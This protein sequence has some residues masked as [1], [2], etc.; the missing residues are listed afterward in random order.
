MIEKLNRTIH[1]GD[2]AIV[3]ELL[4]IETHFSNRK[5]YTYLIELLGMNFSK[6]YPHIKI[7]KLA[8][9]ALFFQ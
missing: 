8:F 1:N 4:M 9:C 7:R 3:S 2:Y 5:K 6:D